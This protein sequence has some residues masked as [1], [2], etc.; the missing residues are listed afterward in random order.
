MLNNGNWNGT[1]VISENWMLEMG[2][3]RPVSSGYYGYLVWMSSWS[4]YAAGLGGQ[5]IFLIP[6]HNLVV[7]FT[8]GV[9]PGNPTN[10]YIYI[11][12]N[13]IIS[14]I[15]NPQSPGPGIPGYSLMVFLPLMIV[16]IVF[17][18]KKMKNKYSLI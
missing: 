11:I 9:Y 2:T 7:V 18:S 4:Y 17:F 8:A 15:V 6:E 14:A 13:F 16:G 10:D 1:Q 12:E 5:C 3:P